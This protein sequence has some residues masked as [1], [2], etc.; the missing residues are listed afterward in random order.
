VANSLLDIATGIRD[1]PTEGHLIRVQIGDQQVYLEP[2]DA[3]TLGG[4]LTGLA[5][6]AIHASRSSRR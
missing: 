3:A 1:T 6:D 5:Q 2:G 4:E